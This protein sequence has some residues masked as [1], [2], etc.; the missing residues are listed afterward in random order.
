MRS[1][2]L[3]LDKRSFSSSQLGSHLLPSDSSCGSEPCLS[4][5]VL[6]ARY[7]LVKKKNDLKIQPTTIF[8]R[9]KKETTFLSGLR[10]FKL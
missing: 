1:I 9:K 7:L 2:S 3:E 10:S 5:H 8:P 4:L 6:G